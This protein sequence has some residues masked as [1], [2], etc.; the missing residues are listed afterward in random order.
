MLGSPEHDGGS[1]LV[2]VLAGLAQ[3]HDPR[4]RQALTALFLVRPDLATAAPQAAAALPASARDRLIYAYIAAVYLQRLWWTRWR[5]YLGDVP[6][7]PPLWID[8]LALPAPHE[9][10]GKAGLVALA[11]RTGGRRGATTPQMGPYLKVGQRLFGQ[12]L[13]ERAAASAQPREALR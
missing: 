5:R 9:R 11:A 6:L 3:S 4:V 2:G 10:F 7:L 12:L 1:D 13:A 8:E